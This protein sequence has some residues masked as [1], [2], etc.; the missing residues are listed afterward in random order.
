MAKK[1]VITLILIFAVLTTA[2][3][4]FASPSA[5][6]YA[7]GYLNAQRVMSPDEMQ[8]ANYLVQRSEILK[9]LSKNK[10]SHTL[11][12][13]LKIINTK[14]TYLDN[15]IKKNRK[16]TQV[17]TVK[18]AAAP[19]VPS[20]PKKPKNVQKAAVKAPAHVVAKPKITSQTAPVLNPVKA[21]ESEALPEIIK[22]KAS[23]IPQKHE[24]Y[25]F[26]NPSNAPVF[27]QTEIAAPK[28][29]DTAPLT[30]AEPKTIEPITR[31]Q[32]SSSSSDFKIV[33]PSAVKT[34][35][36]AL[37]A[38]NTT[39]VSM[40]VIHENDFKTA[41]LPQNAGS[42]IIPVQTP[43][44]PASVVTVMPKPVESH[45]TTVNIPA[46]PEIVSVE[47][48][49]AVSVPANVTQDS[50]LQPQQTLSDSMSTQ[51]V[52][53]P[54]TPAP[55]HIE[56][57]SKVVPVEVKMPM[58]ET[59]APAQ[60]QESGAL[61][62]INWIAMSREEKEMYVFSAMGALVKHDVVSMKP[63]YF[64]IDEL[65]NAL[66]K[67]PSKK[68]QYIDDLFISSIYQNEPDTRSSIDKIRR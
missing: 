46:A 12:H 1:S 31:I 3:D 58:A 7:I 49:P 18:H 15:Q 53:L 2:N 8:L 27:K 19:A 6:Q 20:V 25:R 24:V 54:R 14:I 4:L 17:T 63:S 66:A 59:V 68:D 26:E 51:V 67:D 45:L 38:T 30:P 62:G 5:R 50:A 42:Q 11:K 16:G 10:T 29:L 52:S 34:E 48:V 64:Y 13:Q 21:S 39:P 57:P 35:M 61:K 55:A 9:G 41:V 47:K 65:D 23:S 44:V 36:S 43:A 40:P 37:S 28:V 60:S 22:P 33:Q 56:E 32:T